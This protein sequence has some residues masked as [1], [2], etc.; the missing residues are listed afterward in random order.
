MIPVPPPPRNPASPWGVAQ[1]SPTTCDGR[2]G[3]HGLL[4]TSA[5]PRLSQRLGGI[6][7]CKLTSSSRCIYRMS[8]SDLALS[9][10]AV[11]YCAEK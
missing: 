1:R 2:H 8:L 11:T 6:L 3:N 9:L 5:D 4:R 7:E 10:C